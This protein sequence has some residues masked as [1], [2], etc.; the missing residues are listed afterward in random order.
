VPSRNWRPTCSTFQRE[1]F[2]LTD[3]FAWPDNVWMKPLPRLSGGA[4]RL[5]LRLPPDHGRRSAAARA[6]PHELLLPAD[7]AFDGALH[8]VRP[9]AAR[10]DQGLARATC[11]SAIIASGG[12]SHFVNDEEFDHRIMKMLADYDYEGLAA[13]D[14][15]SYQSGTSEIKLYVSVMKALQDTGA[16]MTLVDY[17][18]CWRTAAGTGEGMGFMYW[19]AANKPDRR[20]LPDTNPGKA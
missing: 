10:C 8:R 12:L 19:K 6:D 5:Q 2:D 15:R 18:P 14:D 9:R 17:V 1:N 20:P 13:V 4:A 7:P 16:E 3:L 11:G